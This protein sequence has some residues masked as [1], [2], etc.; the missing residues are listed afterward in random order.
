MFSSSSPAFSTS[1]VSPHTDEFLDLLACSQSRR[2]DDQRASFSNLPGLR[3]NQ[4][5]SQSVLGQLMASNNRELDDD[6]FEILIKCQVWFFTKILQILSLWGFDLC[7]LLLS[8][9]KYATL[10]IMCFKIRIN[11]VDKE[12]RRTKNQDFFFFLQFLF[13]VLTP[14]PPLIQ[15]LVSVILV[16][17]PC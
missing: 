7:I 5:N 14:P 17:I 6:F 3:L 10:F 2:L 9:F 4:H 1:V 11:L 13:C 15:W 12:E 8:C 16:F